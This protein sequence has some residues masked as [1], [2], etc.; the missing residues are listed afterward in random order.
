MRSNP[1]TVRFRVHI[2]RTK[3]Y[4]QVILFVSRE[5]MFNFEQKL[6]GKRISKPTYLGCCTTRG[7]KGKRAGYVLLCD[8]SYARVGIVA[9]EM[10]HA[11]LYWIIDHQWQLFSNHNKFRIFDERLALIVGELVRQ[12]WVHFFRLGLDKGI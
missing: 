12:Y 3:H 1:P 10:T 5:E 8:E 2:P 4:Y 9:H 6:P 7:R 11:G